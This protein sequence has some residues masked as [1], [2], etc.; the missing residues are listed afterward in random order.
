MDQVAAFKDELAGNP[1]VVAASMVSGV[2]GQRM[3][4]LTVSLPNATESNAENAQSLSEGF[5]MRVLAG[6]ADM[7]KTLGIDFIEGRDFD[8][9]IQLDEQQAFIINQAAADW[10][11]LK[12]PLNTKFTYLYNVDPPKEGKII[13]VTENFHYASLHSEVEPLMMHIYPYFNRYLCVRLQ[14]KNIK[15]GVAGIEQQWTESLPS[16]PFSYFF[17]DPYYDNLYRAETNMG[18]IVSYFSLLAIIIACLG[19]FG[20]VSFITEQ[21]TKEIGIRKIL[22][23]STASIIRSLSAEFV[24]LVLISN[25]LAWVPI[26][27]IM[28]NWLDDFAYRTRLDL[29]VFALALLASFVIAMITISFQSYKAATAKPV[30]AIKYE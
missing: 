21:R 28:E 22:G 6:D 11:E 13:G 30:N 18:L 24:I 27:L 26:Y 9:D 23:A 12:D 16:V 3:P 19:L 7:L 25:V 4:F 29:W 17:L 2:P 20:L 10:L 14:A 1:D 5:G 15:K 8:K